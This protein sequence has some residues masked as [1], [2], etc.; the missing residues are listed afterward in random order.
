[1][2]DRLTGTAADGMRA[3]LD[4]T[5]SPAKP[6]AEKAGTD[7]LTNGEEHVSSL[8]KDTHAVPSSQNSAGPGKSDSYGKKVGASSPEKGKETGHDDG[9][10]L[11]KAEHREIGKVA[12]GVYGSYIRAAGG[13]NVF[14]IL[15][16]L[17]IGQ[18]LWILSEW[19]LAR[20][21]EASDDE[22]KREMRK[23][24]LVYGLFVVGVLLFMPK[25][26]LKL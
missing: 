24:L 5:V 23:W 10:D 17:V 9:H 18:A 20:W 3:A 25:L 13:F 2:G 11:T 7:P 26:Y 15:A 6:D 8:G 19:W 12:R 16:A 22:Q 1:M 14:A 4:T 21:A